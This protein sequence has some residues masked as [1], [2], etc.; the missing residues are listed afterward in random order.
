MRPYPNLSNSCSVARHGPI[1][2]ATS[3]LS[4]NVDDDDNG[5]DDTDEEEVDEEAYDEGGNM[6]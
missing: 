3:T 4:G 5:A 6:E 2:A 1:G